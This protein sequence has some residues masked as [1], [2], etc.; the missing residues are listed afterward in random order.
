MMTYK[1][2]QSAVLGIV[3]TVVMMF[4][5]G[6]VSARRSVVV[7]PKSEVRT[8]SIAHN[9]VMD[10]PFDVI[11]SPAIEPG[12]I[13][14]ESDSAFLPYIETEVSNLTLTVRVAESKP[15]KVMPAV[16][17][18][19]RMHHDWLNITLSGGISVVCDA[20]I[21]NGDMAV[22]MSGG[23]SARMNLMCMNL[24]MELRDYARFE[25]ETEV[26][27][28]NVTLWN[29]SN[30]TMR[31]P[32]EKM[33]VYLTDKAQLDSRKLIDNVCYVNCYKEAHAEVGCESMLTIHRSPDA[34]VVAYG[35]AKV[36]ETIEP[37][38]ADEKKKR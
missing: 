26:V 16:P 33:V 32:V 12:R 7:V 10:G 30:C 24:E 37:L 6:Q 36:T 38:A 27:C 28:A 25:G 5:C 11:L 9:L 2:R 35:N 19:I 31:G 23:A 1:I 8:V 13:E 21:Q 3:L 4:C 22:K 15:R 18:T 17:I 34:K 20:M 14:I 29:N